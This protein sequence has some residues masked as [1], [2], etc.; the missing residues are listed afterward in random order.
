M[1]LC[2]NVHEI[3]IGSAVHIVDTPKVEALLQVI[4][5]W[6]QRRPVESKEPEPEDLTELNAAELREQ[7]GTRWVALQK[8]DM[9]QVGMKYRVVS[10]VVEVWSPLQRRPRDPPAP[11]YLTN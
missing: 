3:K 5:N 11:Y 2:K 9:P 7:M 6:L 1:D 4:E 8:S 10:E